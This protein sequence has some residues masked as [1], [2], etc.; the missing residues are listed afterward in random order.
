MP[1][2]TPCTLAGFDSPPQTHPP[3]SHCQ[4]AGPR[5]CLNRNSPVPSG[6][7]CTPSLYPPSAREHSQSQQ[8]GEF[9]FWCARS[10]CRLTSSQGPRDAQSPPWWCAGVPGTQKLCFLA[11]GFEVAAHPAVSPAVWP[12]RGPPGKGGNESPRL[13]K[14]AGPE[15]A[16]P[17][18]GRPGSPLCPAA[19]DDTG[20]ARSLIFKVHGNSRYQEQEYVDPSLFFFFNA[21]ELP[22]VSGFGRE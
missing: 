8:T 3:A 18:G 21:K 15:G 5:A 4:A 2:R 16:G 13:A 17:G 7:A 10:W 11:H 1:H 22:R 14:Q 20:P 12:G 9:P 19:E 6:P